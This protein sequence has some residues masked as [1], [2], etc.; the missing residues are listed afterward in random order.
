MESLSMIPLRIFFSDVR[1]KH[2]EMHKF[3]TSKMPM[4]SVVSILHSV[5][6]TTTATQKLGQ[7]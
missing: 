6:P 3:L 1:P 4:M 2:K 5:V 7:F